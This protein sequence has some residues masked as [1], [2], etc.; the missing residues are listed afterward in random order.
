MFLKLNYEH[1]FFRPTDTPAFWSHVGYWCLLPYT[2]H[3]LP[4]SQVWT[5]FHD[6]CS[7]LVKKN[8]VTLFFDTLKSLMLPTYLFSFVL[9]EFYQEF[10][11]NHLL[12]FVNWVQSWP[13]ISKRMTHRNM[14]SILEMLT[15]IFNYCFR[16]YSQ[17]GSSN[18][19]D[20]CKYWKI[21]LT[22]GFKITVCLTQ[23]VEWIWADYTLS[24][25]GLKL[26][27]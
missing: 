18:L 15:N 21:I 13:G 19:Y 14:K 16:R 10:F 22:R 6:V 3:D 7:H 5:T 12:A 1:C 27:V 20:Y 24:R 23:N 17:C 4:P 9:I 11:Q 26:F 8:S 25:H 2:C